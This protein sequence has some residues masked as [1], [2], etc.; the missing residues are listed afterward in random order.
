V[1]R[2]AGV[3]AEAPPAEIP[4]HNLDAERAVLGAP[5]QQ[6]VDSLAVF[7]EIRQRGVVPETFFLEACER[8][9]RENT[10]Q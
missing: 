4:P 7:R 5:M 1:S 6:D 10:V 3:V 9:H 8:A 2:T